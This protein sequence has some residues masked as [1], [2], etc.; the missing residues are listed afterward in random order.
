[1]WAL[2]GWSQQTKQEK[3]LS[4]KGRSSQRFELTRADA[5]KIPD[6]KEVEHKQDGKHRL[7]Y[8]PVT[9]TKDISQEDFEAVRASGRTHREVD[10]RTQFKRKGGDRA[11]LAK[12]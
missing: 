11:A 5:Q 4:C 12:L 7:G 10:E 3:R 9:E 8:N 6:W 1:M 2:R